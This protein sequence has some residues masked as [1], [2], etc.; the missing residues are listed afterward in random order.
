MIRIE[1]KKLLDGRSLYWLSQQTGIRWAT[2]AALEK[3]KLKRIDLEA[4]NRICEALECQPGD[5]LV[6]VE[7]RKAGK[8]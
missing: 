6:H 4:L 5:L 1:L 7:R 2:I 3:G 8:R